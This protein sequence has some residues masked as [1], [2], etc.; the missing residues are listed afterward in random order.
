MASITS[1]NAVLTISIASLFSSPQTIYGFAADDVYDL[2]PL[3]AAEALMG[4][5]G[6]QS[7]GFVY[8]PIRQSIALQA[9]SPSNAVFDS[10]WTAQQQIKDV[11]FATGSIALN[12]LNKKYTMV[13]GVLITYPPAPSGKRVLQPRRY[14]ISWQSIVGAPANP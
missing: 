2:D 11:Y 8:V 12:S 10:W 6:I 7:A 3:T 9:D 5:D 4:V 1:A 14:T 13:Q